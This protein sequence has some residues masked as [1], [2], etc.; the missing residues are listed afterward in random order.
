MQILI[1]DDN[2]SLSRTLS[3]ILQKKGHQTFTA[4]NGMKAIEV[5]EK[6]AFDIIFMDIKMPGL[7]GV[8]T[9][10][11]VKRIQPNAVVIMMTAYTATE[12]AV[13]AIQEGAFALIHKPL[14]FDQIFSLI[15]RVQEEKES[16]FILVV[17]DDENTR[18]MLRD[19][20][21]EKGYR[22]TVAKTGEDA[23]AM[24]KVLP[25]DVTIIDMNL[26]LLNGLETFLAIQEINPQAIVIMM[27]GQREREID[28]FVKEA[29]DH[30]A[31]TCI[32][33]PFDV[34][35]L[36]TMVDEISTQKLVL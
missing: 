5:I 1:V 14:D 2:E 10:K 8:D 13:E 36:V 12:L 9:Y 6:K 15:N 26:P 4:N 19:A 27:T 32:Y 22:V 35:E 28:E 23:I 29:M 25:H 11:Q 18:L 24:T 17:D 20:F 30:N 33:K 16:A 7:N 34:L 21:S 3:F 31:Y